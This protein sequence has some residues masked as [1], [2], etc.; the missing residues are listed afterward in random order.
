MIKFGAVN[1]FRAKKQQYLGIRFDSIAELERYKHLQLLQKSG[2]IANLL[3]SE[4]QPKKKRY[5]VVNPVAYVAFSGKRYKS[6][7]TYYEPDFEY[8]VG[9]LHV[10]E[11]VKGFVTDV[12]AIKAKL[13]RAMYPSF[14][15]R[16][17]KV[18]KRKAGYVF[19]DVE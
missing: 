13:F 6:R 17:V 18:Y 12:F 15:F 2:E 4:K 1:K 3:P 9:N 7:A 5:I 8:D 11:D 19:K 10:V 14:V 16:I